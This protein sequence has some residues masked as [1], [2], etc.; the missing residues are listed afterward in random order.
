MLAVTSAQ[1]SGPAEISS[2]VRGCADISETAPRL[3]CYDALASDIARED[4]QP[5]VMVASRETSPAPAASPDDRFGLEQR[6]AREETL[7]GDARS[8]IQ[9][10]I[11]ALL[12]RR[13]GRVVVE[14]DNGQVWA[15]IEPDAQR[16]LAA[17]GRVSI[18]R[19]S[20]GS[21]LLVTES[22]RSVRV[23]RL[24]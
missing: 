22:R 21:F 7:A 4:A 6:R 12:A 16:A 24:E 11:T 17:G 3:A 19:A 10:S 20:L 2:R 8:E 13:G 23:R 9:G 18:R 5:A 15:T 1:A 14:L